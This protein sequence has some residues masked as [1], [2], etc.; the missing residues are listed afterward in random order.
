MSL[1]SLFIIGMSRLITIAFYSVGAAVTNVFGPVILQT[2]PI[3][4]KTSTLMNAPF[5]ALQTLAVS[6]LADHHVAHGQPC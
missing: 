5:G 6:L 4:K 2:L 1:E 3:Q